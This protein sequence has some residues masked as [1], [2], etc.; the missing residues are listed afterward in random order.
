MPDDENDPV[1]AI[2]LMEG[3][4]VSENVDSSFGDPRK[5]KLPNL[6]SNIVRRPIVL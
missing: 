3:F 6:M 2:V 1:F 5:Y 4:A